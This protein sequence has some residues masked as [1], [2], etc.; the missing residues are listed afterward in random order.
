[1]TELRTP[2]WVMDRFGLNQ[3]IL[4]CFDAFSRAAITGNEYMTD[5][6]VRTLSN[7]I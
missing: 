1:M 4:V 6:K 7:M 3:Q 5:A 2:G